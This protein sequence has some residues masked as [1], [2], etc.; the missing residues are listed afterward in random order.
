MTQEA[1]KLVRKAKVKLVLGEGCNVLNIY[2]FQNILP[3]YSIFVYS[4]K[5]NGNKCYCHSQSQ[6][7]R[8]NLF[9]FNDMKHFIVI[10][11]RKQ[12]FAKRYECAECL[13]LHDTIPIEHKCNTCK[14]HGLCKF[15]QSVP[16]LFCNV[17]C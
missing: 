7:K 14:T 8:I 12:F 9:Y 11:N 3:E 4:D 13:V 15:E 6:G 10:K 1:E 2:A 16:C 5:S 17:I